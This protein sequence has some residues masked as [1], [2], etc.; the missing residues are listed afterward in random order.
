[1]PQSICRDCLSFLAAVAMVCLSF[2]ANALTVHDD[3]GEQTLPESPQRVVALNWSLTADLLE[4][5][6]TPAGVA[7]TEG[8][9]TWVVKP[10][11]PESVVDVGSRSEP[12]IERIAALNPDLILLSTDQRGLADTM[13]QVAPVLW[14]DAFR[15]DHDNVEKAREIYLSL[16]RVFEREERA[17]EQLAALDQRFAELRETLEAHFGEDLPEVTAVLI[18]GPTTVRLY[19]DNS[20]PQH[21]LTQLGLEPAMPQPR[22]Q[23]GQSK[24]Q[25]SDL[26]A[27]E[28]GIL[29]YLKPTRLA[30][31]LFSTPLWQALPVV[32]QERVAAVEATWPYGGVLSLRYLAEHMTDA[33]LTIEP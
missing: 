15:R 26:R 13:E 18:G 27:M 2:S 8:Y 30:G 7:D 1:M 9:N 11:L 24:K 19:G 25:V 12:N 20:L 5:G 3:R 28:D 4:L 21:A 23:W 16:G 6:V 14:F 32:K 10:P 31:D 22:S 17:R 29:L 33:L